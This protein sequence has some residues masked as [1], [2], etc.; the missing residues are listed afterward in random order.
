MADSSPAVSRSRSC[1]AGALARDAAPQMPD[2]PPS[3]S[4]SLLDTATPHQSTIGRF[5][6]LICTLLLFGVTKNYMDRQVISVL[7]TTLQANLHWNDIDYSNMVF[8]FQGA[9]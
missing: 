3:P 4:Q 2:A 5:R 9:Y 6:W 7:K 8:I 1:G